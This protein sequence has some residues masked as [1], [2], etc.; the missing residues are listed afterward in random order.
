MSFRLRMAV[1]AAAYLVIITSC[2]TNGSN[3]AT[4]SYPLQQKGLAVGGDVQSRATDLVA[5]GITEAQAKK[6]AH[7]CNRTVEVASGKQPCGHQISKTLAAPAASAASAAP[8]A[9]GRPPCQPGVCLR[10]WDVSNVSEL[11]LQAFIDIKD[12]RPGE[13]L[14]NSE[15]DD[16][17]LRV[18]VPTSSTLNQIVPRSLYT[19]PPGEAPSSTTTPSTATPI[20]TSPSSPTP[21]SPSSPTPTSPSSLPGGTTAPASSP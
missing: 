21:T 18:G 11:G 9:P 15:P 20:P 14:C 7:A 6:I 5:R 2:G 19:T 4:T 8:A 16:V 13:S 17:C 10:V 1:G 12:D 3:P